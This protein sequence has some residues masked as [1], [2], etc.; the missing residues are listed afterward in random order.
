MML[1][2]AWNTR[3]GA[4]AEILS[5]LANR[6]Y[7]QVEEDVAR[8][9]QFDDPPVWSAGNYRG[10]ASKIDLIFAISK[11]VTQKDLSEFFTLAEYVLSESDPALE[12]PEDDRGAAGIY[13]KVRDHSA[14]LREGICETLVIL[15]VHGNSLFKDRLGID[16]DARVAV[17]I[18]QLLSLLT[19]DKLMSHERDL[20]RYAE[21]AP[22][23]FLGLL[24][25][26][27]KK[28]NPVVLGLLKPASSG[29]F[30]SCPR[31]G[32]LWALECLAW[33]SQNLPRVV[34]ILA[35]LSR[36]EIND[37]WANKPI[38]SLE[39]I[40][41]SWMPQTAASLEERLKV[42]ELLTKR[43]PDIGWQICIEQFGQGSRIGDYSYRPH[44]RSDASGAGKPL[45]TRDPIVAFNRK[46]LDIALAWPCHDESTF[47]D[48]VERLE[49]MT[50]ED[51]A[52]L[53]QLIE[54]WAD[55]AKTTDKAKAI[56][57][58]RIRRF[59]LTRV[60]RR[61][62]SEEATRNR[63]CKM[64]AELKPTDPVIRHGWLFAKQW[65][66][67][68]AEE[69]DGEDFD[70][71]KREERIHTLR[72]GALTD[73]W[74]ARGF[75]GVVA[76][77]ADSEAPTTV[78]QYAGLCPP[79]IIDP[80]TRADF[81]L[82]CLQVRGSLEQK[83]DSCMLG[84]LWSL[85]SGPRQASLRAVVQD[86]DPDNRVRLFRSAPFEKSTWQTVDEYGEDVATRYWKGVFPQRNRRHS[87]A[88]L[89]E[90]VDRLLD[91]E[92]PRAAF[93]AAHMDWA[94]LE[95]SRLKRL[96][97]M[98]ATVDGEPQNT[99]RLDA[100]YVSDALDAL[101]GRAGVTADE[102]ALMEFRFVGALDRSK[103]GIP[104]L[105]RQI[106]ESPLV[107][108]QA[109]ALMWKRSD[110]GEDPPEWRIDDPERRASVASA[111]RRVL[112]QMKRIP[113]TNADGVIVA[114]DLIDFL[115]QVRALA[116]QHGRAD[117]VDQCLG[118]L[119]AKAPPENTGVWPCVP[120]CEAM[121]RLA[122]PEIAIG[123]SVGV[124][125]SLGAVS[126]G[127]GGA[128]ERELAT[129][130]RGLAQLVAF[131]CPYVSSVLEDI[132]LSYDRQAE[133]HDSE[134]KVSKRLRH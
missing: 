32:L 99:Y 28:P 126:R 78:G 81:L 52:K 64:Y 56:L 16:V 116:A 63:A 23:A 3:S 111:M 33:K 2:G 115:N 83:A 43:F 48:L 89:N 72:I 85:E 94:R 107:Y 79:C 4:D 21:A 133:W 92:R 5:V 11:F 91:A 77:L 47:G 98:V 67:E 39:A 1:I 109:M 71:M 110:N 112:N 119:L 34:A 17:L 68:S 58:E 24:E 19:L 117:I 134:A 35:E 13:G 70:F 114:G 102:M 29:P 93:H 51:Q 41:R 122:S 8:L 90:L 96:L 27:L 73:I 130:Y 104:N 65:V 42:L 124:R 120:V 55:Y 108:M 31:T 106:A 131:E 101:D 123:F 9:V 125:N 113:G 66:E 36:T 97:A 40:F 26:D 53:W 15:S 37:N 61:R 84:F 10:V 88:D 46:A 80:R 18:G 121:E 87:D 86:I 22:E 14:A 129:K 7:E 25:A 82:R 57:R 60:G 12:L 100:H 38:G 118:Q 75:E 44:W 76:L 132:A 45:D 49:G 103:H 50:A 30:G 20:P 6:P 54:N 105:E 95:T 74:S 59:A 127:E 62:V 69:L 128:Q